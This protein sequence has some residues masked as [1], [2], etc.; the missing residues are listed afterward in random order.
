MRAI[1]VHRDVLVAR[2]A[3]WQTNCAVVRHGEETFV[4]DSPVLP[5]ELDA[6]RA[7]VDQAGFAAPRGLLA[8]H[9]DWDHLLGRLAFPGL[10]LGCAESTAARL[11]AAPG[12]AQR[13]LR[14]FDEELAIER[15]PLALGA[16]QP[17]P[18]P[19]S[20]AIGE[21]E[22]ELHATAG[23]SEDGMALWVPWA[24]VL[25]AGD[26]LSPIELPT[27]HAVRRAPGALPS[28]VADRAA[29]GEPLESYVATLERLRP[30]VE[31]AAHVVPGHGP[32][33]DTARALSVMDEDL[34]YLRGLRELG[35]A[36]RLPRGRD[37]RAQRARHEQNLACCEAP[38][39]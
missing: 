35:A 20:C 27:L 25:L 38:Q 29:A 15:A 9:G 8:T 10:T 17:L 36:V 13:E 18:V 6:L 26:Y 7:L 14:E 33:I 32:A 24:R 5:E 12:A 28:R 30:L 1:A 2:S 21:Q 37:G 23:H 39:P 22:L 34:E 16:I 31:R 3:I 11:R 19:G 4:I